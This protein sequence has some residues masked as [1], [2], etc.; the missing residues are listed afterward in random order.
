MELRCQA[1]IERTKQE[2]SESF[3]QTL[4]RTK[5]EL[6]R[7]QLVVQKL[8]KTNSDSDRVIDSLKVEMGKMKE[9]HLNEV[10]SM[11]MSSEREKETLKER[12]REE[13]EAAR[14]SVRQECAARMKEMS[15]AHASAVEAA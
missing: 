8:K 13:G 3:K 12:L 1:D 4:A 6:E 5:A 14:A 15:K 10:A 9:S 7:A 2:T 11:K